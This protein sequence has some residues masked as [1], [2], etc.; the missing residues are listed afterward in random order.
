MRTILRIVFILTQAFFAIYFIAD[1]YQD[2]NESPTVT[3]GTRY[4][5]SQYLLLHL[6]SHYKTAYIILN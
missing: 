1:A 6:L 3:S 5:K 4:L 2:W